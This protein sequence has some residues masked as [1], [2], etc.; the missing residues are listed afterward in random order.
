MSS[1]QFPW[2]NA[3]VIRPVTGSV[4]MNEHPEINKPEPK[5]KKSKGEQAIIAERKR[6]EA[7]EKARARKDGMPEIIDR[8]RLNTDD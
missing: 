1:A 3:Q 4:R 2:M 8:T 5:R 6:V 7:R